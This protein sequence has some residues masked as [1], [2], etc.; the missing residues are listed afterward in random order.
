M[1][2]SAESHPNKWITKRQFSHK[3]TKSHCFLSPFYHKGDKR[4]AHHSQPQNN[5]NNLFLCQTQILLSVTSTAS[6]A[7][8]YLIAESSLTSAEGAV[9][10]VS[11]LV[12]S[13][14]P[15]TTPH[16]TSCCLPSI[17]EKRLT[18]PPCFVLRQ[19]PKL[20]SDLPTTGCSD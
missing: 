13:S 16:H 20:T 15:Q 7:I 4:D 17:L 3:H 11:R 19:S 12:H 6:S 2:N 1:T 9:A 5:Q 18:L 8:G 14:C 10:Y